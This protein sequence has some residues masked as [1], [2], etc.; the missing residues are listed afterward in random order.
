RPP[1]PPLF[2]YTTLFRSL[3]A[4]GTALDGRLRASLRQAVGDIFAAGLLPAAQRWLRANPANLVQFLL[5]GLPDS[6]IIDWLLEAV[7]AP[8]SEEHTSELQSRFDLV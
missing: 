3:A 8:R 7:K 1:L 6:G 2:P 5:R 4:E